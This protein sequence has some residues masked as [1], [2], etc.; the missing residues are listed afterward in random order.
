MSKCKTC[1]GDFSYLKEEGINP[2]SVI[3]ENG[4]CMDCAQSKYF[5]E[6]L[7]KTFLTPKEENEK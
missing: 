7:N 1:N 2:N 6:L 3:D 4:D 5:K